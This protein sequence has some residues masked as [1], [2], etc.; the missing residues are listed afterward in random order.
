MSV[1]LPRRSGTVFTGPRSALELWHATGAPQRRMLLGRWSGVEAPPATRIDIAILAPCPQEVSR[2]WLDGSIADAAGRLDGD[3]LVWVVVGPRWRGVAERAIRRSGLVLLD[4][5]LAIPPWPHSAHLVPFARG[6]FADV[7]P[8]RLRVSRIAAGAIAWLLS[9]RIPAYIVRRVAP[10]CALLAARAPASTRVF[11]WLGEL[12]GREVGTAA[13]STG[14]RYDARTAVAMR[15][16]DAGTPDL[17][18]KTALDEGGAQRL[19]HEG[20]ALEHLGPAAAGAGAQVPIR[21]ASP[22]PWLL[23]TGPIP[24]QSVDDLLATAPARLEEVAAGV[25]QWLLAWNSATAVDVPAPAELLAETVGRPIARLVAARVAPHDYGAAVTDLVGELAGRS[26]V[27]V[28]VHND[29]TMANVL[30]DGPR[31]GILDWESAVGLGFPL[32]DLWYM[33]VDALARAR[34]IAHVRAVEAFSRP[35]ADVSEALTR[36]PARHAMC[37]GLGHRESIL[38]FHACWLGHADDELRRGITDGPFVHVL[39]A[40]ATRR[41]LWPATA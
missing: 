4:A 29:L 12:D 9:S 21:R 20:E 19:R 18:V 13:V 8:R 1:G 40:V 24:G 16:D 33:L 36:L 7:G 11:A 15:F 37:L 3:G 14:S 38:S 26:L 39:R 30:R 2:V 28:A 5:V 17:V 34:G 32:T 10:G 25:A 22:Q 41:L 23:A 6:A 31:L 35:E 27:G